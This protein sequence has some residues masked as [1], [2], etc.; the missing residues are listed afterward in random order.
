MTMLF[1]GYED[2]GFYRN[3]RGF[4]TPTPYGEIADMLLS[5]VR[6]A[7][8]DRYAAALITSGTPLSL[9]LFNKCKSYAAAGGHLVIFAGTV[10]K[11]RHLM[12]YDPGYLA[13]FGLDA[14]AG[15]EEWSGS[16]RLADGTVSP[17]E[18][19]SVFSAVSAESACIDVAGLDGRPLVLEV[20]QGDGKVTLIL[21]EDGLVRTLE[22]FKPDNRP[23]EPI[24]QPYELAAFIRSSLGR[25]FD[26]LRLVAVDNRILQYCL[27]IKDEANYTLFVANDTLNTEHFN[28]VSPVGAIRSVVPMPILDGMVDLDEFLPLGFQDQHQ[29][30][31][32]DGVYEIRPGDCLLFQVGTDALPLE[33]I[34]E[35][36][37]SARDEHLFLALGYDRHSIK[38]FVLAQPTLQHHF[39]GLLVPAEYFD[40]LD[41]ISAAREAHYLNLQKICVYV[42]F[43]RMINH[44]PDLSLIGNLDYRYEEAMNR[45]GRILDKV[46][47]Y[48][49]RGA[50]FTAQRNAENEYSM[51]Q[52]KQG[53]MK[54]F[55]QISQL[56]DARGI[57]FLLQNRPTI[58]KADE[59]LA[60]KAQSPDLRLAINAAYA[61]CELFTFEDALDRADLLMLSAPERDQYGQ[62]YPVQSPIS[63]STWAGRLQ[64]ACRQARAKGIPV[65]LC[66]GYPDWDAVTADLSL[67]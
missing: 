48:D 33:P 4:T 26:D 32:S 64:Q 36:L 22:A 58:V 17:V 55:G 53:L 20:A 61:A 41:A 49:C 60:Y 50:L 10:A 46:A 65:V 38:D 16:A 21:A 23:N 35:S 28:I 12:A 6:Q 11:Y 62:M 1:P 5:D 59:L 45:I 18:T 24:C 31:Q 67:L 14:L 3:E 15:P 25:I 30:A 43:T 7:V 56:C 34:A 40:R 44:F 57:R 39:A 2:A 27:A 54:A 66:A 37:P 8:L 52:A 47:L 13:F 9:E 51:E 63:G 42:D 19:L 29:P